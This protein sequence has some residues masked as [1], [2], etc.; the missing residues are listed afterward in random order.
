MYYFQAIIMKIDVNRL[1][2][3]MAVMINPSKNNK[4]AMVPKEIG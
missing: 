1:I 3:S 2:A 4:V